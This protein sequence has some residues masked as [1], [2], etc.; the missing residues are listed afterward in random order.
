[1]EKEFNA[2]EDAKNAKRIKSGREKIKKWNS[3]NYRQNSIA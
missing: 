1:V 3:Q 2:K